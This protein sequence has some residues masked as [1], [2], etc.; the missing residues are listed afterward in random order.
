MKSLT[1]SFLTFGL[2]VDTIM[3]EELLNMILLECCVLCSLKS[4]FVYNTVYIKNSLIFFAVTV[5]VFY[6]LN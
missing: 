4:C 6:L 2:S 3:H 1:F 5:I